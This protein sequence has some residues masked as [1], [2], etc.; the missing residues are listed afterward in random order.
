MWLDSTPYWNGIQMDETALVVLLL[1][2]T[3][4][5]GIL[6]ASDMR[7]YWP[8][9]R[10]SAQYIVCNG[11][12]TQEDRWE[13]DAGYSPFTLAAEIAALLAAADLADLSGE[14][15]E[16]TYLRE[17]ADSWNASIE[18]WIYVRDTD[19]SRQF[20]VAGYYVRIVPPGA[21]PGSIAQATY[22]IPN[23]A[24]GGE[25]RAGQIVSPDVLGLVRFGLRSADDP[26]IVDTL[27]L[28]DALLKL[29]TPT[30]P[31]WH[32]YNED[33]YGEHEDGSPFDGT[34]IGRAWPLLTGERAHYE[35]ARQQ[36][37]QAARLMHA[38]TSFASDGGLIPEQ[39]W[40][41]ADIP[42]R[43]LSFGR[44]SGSAMPL[45]WA[46]AEYIKLRRSLLEGRVFD[47]PPQPYQRYVVDQ[48]GSPYAMWRFTQKLRSMPA[49]RILRIELQAPA[50]VHW[51]SDGWRTTQ[52]LNTRDTRLGVYVADL[53]TESLVSGQVVFTFYWRQ[54]EKWEGTNF[55][56]MIE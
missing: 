53:P 52:D 16:A 4:R 3:R 41:A 6:Q 23:R 22:D 56:V 51:S 17:T 42:E 20:G 1:D 40:D 26:R 54:T 15:R 55:A 48:T 46:H 36:F 45:V 21:K 38:M 2:A 44:P 8:M 5:E 33:G 25:F 43:E 7:R 18:R 12:S 35:I 30:G 10:R 27:R 11:P 49:G 34:G 50:R 47:M 28:V 29:E 32:R 14:G 13:E 39:I 19:L 9:V 31:C 24:T 37:D